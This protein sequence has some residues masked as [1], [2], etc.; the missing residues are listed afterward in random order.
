MNNKKV[1]IKNQ[2]SIEDIINVC[3]NNY[4]VVLSSEAIKRIKDSRSYVDSLK[5]NKQLYYGINTGLGDLC[6]KLIDNKAQ[7]KY[8]N[9][10]LLSHA[11]GSGI[12]YPNEV[13]RAAILLL[14]NSISKGYSGTSFEVVSFYL[15]M[16]NENIT[17]V[18]PQKGSLGASG[19]LVPL[20]HT[21]LPLIGYGK[22]VHNE[23]IYESRDFFSKRGIKT[24][25]LKAKDAL[26]I[27]NGTHYM[28]ALG[29]IILYD[30]YRLIKMSDC[31]ASLTFEALNG[32]IS[33][34]NPKIHELRKHD[35]QIK[36]AKIMN[37]LL[38]NSE[39]IKVI[40]SLKA[41]DAYSIRCIPQVH[42]ASKDAFNYV[43]KI[44]N[45]EINSVT[46]N[47]LVFYSDKEILSG[48]N[49]HGQ[50]L[51]IS[52]DF[53]C[54]AL[55]ELCNISE[56]RIERLVNCNLSGLNPFLVK[57]SGLNTGFMILQYSA[58]SLVSENKVLSHPASVDSIPSSA[59]QEDHVS[60]GS[61]SIRKCSEILK[62]LS[63]V[64]SIELICA[65]QAIDLQERRKMGKGT[66]T[67][68]K[69]IRE[70]SSFVED[71]R[72]FYDDINIIEE[73]INKEELLKG[74]KKEIGNLDF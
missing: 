10:I 42:G 68:Y 28:T 71:D 23:K 69:M 61:I 6:D 16:L 7:N 26:S 2:L 33:D 31:S 59:N 35:G 20:A 56:R 21:A 38:A 18:V 36:T 41:Q 25:E 3:R 39:Y 43:K 11:C 45:T 44:I 60:M 32:L 52:F 66:S 53:L 14:I 70:K 9:N 58:A 4:K 62:N 1:T 50:P 27:I 24:L 30:S 5:E 64:L 47:P 13:V 57:N 48:G 46:D 73:M 15:M 74:I 12:R 67:I 63:R 8:Q 55:S 65:C 72:L 40:P 22:V 51:A 29:T 37:N 54:I 49:F 34:I 19:D 17:P